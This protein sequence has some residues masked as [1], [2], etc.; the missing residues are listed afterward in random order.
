MAP[1]W[2]RRRNAL[3]HDWLKN[4]F[5]RHLRAFVARTE[6]PAPDQER[7]K[8]FVSEDWPK[9]AVN[10]ERLTDLLASAESEL[11]PRQL[12]ERPPLS[13]CSRE[14][15]AWLS[16]VVHALWLARTSIRRK[17]AGVT[18]AFAEADGSYRT[19]D[20]LLSSVNLCDVERLRQEA[21]T[22]GEFD[23]AVTRL[24]ERIHDLPHGIQVV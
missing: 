16:G 18:T 1:D 20:P 9:W 4:E 2:Q 15:Q 10:R 14:N 12:L 6:A 13:R 21:G 5:T 11:S 23:A 24:S 7:L 19:L 17:V 8:E 22:F 3:N